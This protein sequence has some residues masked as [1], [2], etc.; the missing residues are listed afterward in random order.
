MVELSEDEYE[1]LA[2]AAEGTKM[3]ANVVVFILLLA[4]TG[5]IV[6]LVTMWLDSQAS[7]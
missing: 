3:A 5:V 6:W 7:I 4:A 2:K 1:R